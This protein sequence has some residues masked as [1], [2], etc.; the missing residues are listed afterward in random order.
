[1]IGAFAGFGAQ[2]AGLATLGDQGD[3]ESGEVLESN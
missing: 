1:M 2:P 3:V